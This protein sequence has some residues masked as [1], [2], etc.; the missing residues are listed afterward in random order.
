MKLK[1]IIPISG[2]P[3]EGLISSE[4]YLKKWVSKD[5]EISCTSLKEGPTSL[6][7]DIDTALAI[8]F[9]AEAVVEA[10]GEGFDGVLVS[11]FDD[12]GI[13]AIREL[14]NIP[15]IGAFDSSMSV[16]VHLLDNVTIISPSKVC[17]PSTQHKVN[18]SIY[19]DFVKNIR[20]IDTAIEDIISG[21]ALEKLYNEV[22]E[23]AKMDG[24]EGIILGCTGFYDLLEPLEAKLEEN[25]IDTIAIEPSKVAILELEQLVRLG[26]RHSKNTYPYRKYEEVMKN[27]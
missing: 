16:C 6:E 3:E 8:P 9:I 5:T 12:P 18:A 7:S 26:I 15:V 2:L 21:N 17:I 1:V 4:D 25:S 13:R 19:R 24:I 10:E 14:V 11:C 20:S 22:I 27:M 23:A